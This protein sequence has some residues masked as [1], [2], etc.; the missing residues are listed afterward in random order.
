ME[1]FPPLTAFY[2]AISK[3]ARIG[4]AHI[5]VYM[6]LLQ[7][8]NLNNGENPIL[9]ERDKVMKAAKIN[10]RHTYNK[11]INDLKDYGYIGY[12]P[13]VNSYS[14]SEIVLKLVTQK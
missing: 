14:A 8:W 1:M 11:C 13:S 12:K 4:A 7:Q 3:D 9:I 5:S 2:N 10:G 6:A